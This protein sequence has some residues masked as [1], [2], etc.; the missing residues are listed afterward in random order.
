MQKRDE[1]ERK[2]KKKKKKERKGEKEGKGN[3]KTKSRAQ[4]HRWRRRTVPLRSP[5]V[6][7]R[8]V[9]DKRQMG[10]KGLKLE[11]FLD[12]LDM[13]EICNNSYR[14][15]VYR[16]C[17][18]RRVEI[19]NDKSQSREVPSLDSRNLI[20]CRCRHAVQ[21]CTSIDDL[22]NGLT[23]LNRTETR[24]SNVERLHEIIWL[25]YGS[26]RCCN[27]RS[28]LLPFPP[29]NKFLRTSTTTQERWSEDRL[30]F[31]SDLQH[32]REL[33]H[34]MHWE[35]WEV[36]ISHLRIQL[37]RFQLPAKRSVSSC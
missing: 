7:L 17:S 10:G 32:R 30:E 2:K 25:W 14:A 8:T 3:P 19:S 6:G 26:F 23:S 29:F 37:L 15:W 20:L 36:S 24:L 35:V 28:S 16:F 27:F 5:P 34:S 1:E 9:R 31:L 33:V 18:R 11:G 22:E 21:T 13:Y 12:F 4:S